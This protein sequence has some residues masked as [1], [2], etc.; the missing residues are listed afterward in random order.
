MS[1]EKDPDRCW[2]QP[3]GCLLWMIVLFC[4]MVFAD[5]FKASFR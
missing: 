1:E 4:L 5:A 2:K 3:L